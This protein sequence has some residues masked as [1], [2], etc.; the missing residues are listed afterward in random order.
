MASPRTFKGQRRPWP[1]HP[2]SCFSHPHRLLL[3]V[4]PKAW[5]DS[6]CGVWQERVRLPTPGERPLQRPFHSEPVHVDTHTPPS[7]A[8]CGKEVCG[9]GGLC[10]ELGAFRKSLS[11]AGGHGVHPLSSQTAGPPLLP[12]IPPAMCPSLDSTDQPLWRCKCRPFLAKEYNV[13]SPEERK[14]GCCG[15]AGA[16]TRKGGW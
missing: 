2:E 10:A 12:L 8:Q 6:H 4:P 13:G 7:V 14:G 5:R 3:Q 1:F 11:G 16:D 9:E 15:G